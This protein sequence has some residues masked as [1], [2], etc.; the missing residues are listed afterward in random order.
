MTEKVKAMLAAGETVVMVNVNYPS[1]GLVE[2]IGKLGF[3]IAFIDCEKGSASFERVEEMC[4]A[5]RAAGICAVVRPWSNEPG[6]IS[7]FLDVGA[8]GIMAAAIEDAAAATALVESIRYARHADFDRKLVIAMIES[9][10]S[11]ARLPALLPVPG[12]D[13]WFVGPNDFAHRMGHPGGG[14]RP[15]VRAAVDATLAA[16]VAGKRHAGTLGLRDTMASLKAAGVQLLM[17]RIN[18]MLARGAAEMR[19]ALGRDKL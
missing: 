14:A 13:V 8:D 16:I 1:P 19:A 15:N 2:Q 12:I 7:R 11:A 10:E 6:L 3:D 4:R 5:A 9:P 17:T 18:D